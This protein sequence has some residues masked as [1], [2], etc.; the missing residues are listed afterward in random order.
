MFGLSRKRYWMEHWT[1]CI[2]VAVMLRIDYMKMNSGTSKMHSCFAGDD[3]KTLVHCRAGSGHRG[4]RTP[5]SG[6]GASASIN[7]TFEM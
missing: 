1:W 5:S 6:E 4:C 3:E 2:L 7:L